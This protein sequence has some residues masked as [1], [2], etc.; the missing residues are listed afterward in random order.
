MQIQSSRHFVILSGTGIP[1][2]RE[3]ARIWHAR[4]SNILRGIPLGMTVLLA[5]A[6]LFVTSVSRAQTTQPSIL[7]DVG[8]DQKLDAQVPADL[9]F[10]DENGATVQ[11]SQ[12]YGKRPIVLTLVY[13]KCPMLCTMVLNDLDRVLGAMQMNVGEQFDIVTVSFDPTETPELAAKKK[14]QYVRTYG[15]PHAEE[16][17][18]FL[19]GDQ[20]NISK[21][22]QAVGFRYAWDDKWKQ[23]AHASGIMLLTPDGK[24]S[25]YFYGVEYSARDLRLAVAEAGQGKISTPT[26]TILLYCFHYDPATGK[27]SL[28]V[29]RFVQI[30]AILTMGAIG[31]FWL[32]MWRSGRKPKAI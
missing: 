18:H 24:V 10:K 29:T 16:G 13:Y 7:N 19:T 32:M 20:E 31:T 2:K 3:V 30:G 22:T 28:I 1:H 15:R 23:Y 4:V 25:K 11:L 6:L 21:L 17:W 8:I 14:H 5:C 12:Y 9:T 27:Y 26:E